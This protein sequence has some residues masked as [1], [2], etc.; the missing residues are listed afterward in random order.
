[1]CGWSC[2]GEDLRRD[3]VGKQVS[4]CPILLVPP[5]STLVLTA[6]PTTEQG[7]LRGAS[8]HASQLVRQVRVCWGDMDGIAWLL[9]SVGVRHGSNRA[10]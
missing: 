8:R 4:Q 2:H 5:L 3:P 1:M 6:V 9:R 10:F 7:A